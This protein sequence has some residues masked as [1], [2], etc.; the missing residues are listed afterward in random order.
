[1]VQLRFSIL[2]VA[3]MAVLAG[4]GVAHEAATD[5][6]EAASEAPVAKTPAFEPVEVDLERCENEL[7]AT[8]GDNA[9]ARWEAAPPE[10]RDRMCRQ[11]LDLP[12]SKEVEAK[13]KE[14]IEANP[15]L[16]WSRGHAPMPDGSIRPTAEVEAELGAEVKRAIEEMPGAL[17]AAGN[18]ANDSPQSKD[19]AARNECLEAEYEGMSIQQKTERS[20]EINAEAKARGVEPADVVGC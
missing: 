7:Y 19:A 16:D 9:A 20:R 14:A 5:P 2:A 6:E 17:D 4:C 13:A 1:M 10:E 11:L 18:P 15:G 8:K 3:A 12:S